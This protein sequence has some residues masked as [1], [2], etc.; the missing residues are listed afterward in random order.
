MLG[1]SPDGGCSWTLA[2]LCGA[3][4]TRM[5]CA[6]LPPELP[7]I[8]SMACTWQRLCLALTAFTVT[9]GCRRVML[10]HSSLRRTLR[11]RRASGSPRSSGRCARGSRAPGPP[12]PCS[13]PPRR[14]RQQRRRAVGSRCWSHVR[15]EVAGAAGRVSVL[16]CRCSGCW[17]GRLASGRWCRSEAVCSSKARRPSCRLHGRSPDTKHGN[18]RQLIK[19]TWRALVASQAHRRPGHSA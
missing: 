19:G 17:A 18:A 5:T 16:T 7:S 3:H 11:R 1:S 12:A 8:A 6:S 13:A 4:G 2:V 15:A 9:S 10:R 14:R